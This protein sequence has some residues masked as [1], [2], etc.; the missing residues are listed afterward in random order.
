MAGEPLSRRELEEL[1]AQRSVKVSY[2]TIRCW[3]QRFGRL[4]AHTLRR[5][6]PKPTGRWHPDEMVANI[7]GK[8]MFLQRAVDDEDEGLDMLPA[9]AHRTKAAATATA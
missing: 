5:S 8:R 7:G 9:E 3:T 4:F 2:E 1:L 6:R